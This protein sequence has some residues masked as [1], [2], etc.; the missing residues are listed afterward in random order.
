MISAV[1]GVVQPAV[2]ALLHALHTPQSLAAL[3][4]CGTVVALIMQ[5]NNRRR[6]HHVHAFI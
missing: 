3:L 2:L 6:T 5:S 4:V 1:A